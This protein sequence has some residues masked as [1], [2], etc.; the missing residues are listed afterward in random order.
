LERFVISGDLG[1]AFTCDDDGGDV[2][3]CSRLTKYKS[4]PFD[5]DEDE[6]EERGSAMMVANPSL[7]QLQLQLQQLREMGKRM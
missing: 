1:S 4:L 3:G 7:Q 6:D 5:D 2:A